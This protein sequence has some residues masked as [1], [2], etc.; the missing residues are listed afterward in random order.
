MLRL[1]AKEL[2]TNP[3]FKASLGWYQNWKRRHSVSLR[4]KTTLTQRLPEDLEEKIV[5]FHWFIIAAR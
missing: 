4:T 1:K 5:Q 3:S 2:S